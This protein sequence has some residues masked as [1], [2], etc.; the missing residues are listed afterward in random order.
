MRSAAIQRAVRVG[1]RTH[2]ERDD[3]VGVRAVAPDDERA[4]HSGA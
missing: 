3:V 1:L 2:N 4:F